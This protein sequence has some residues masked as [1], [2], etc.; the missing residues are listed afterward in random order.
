MASEGKDA[1]APK[2]VFRLDYKRPPFTVTDI[3]LAVALEPEAT[4]VS[5]TL[6]VRRTAAAGDGDD[7]RLDG[8]KLFDA[9]K[10][11]RVNGAELAEGKEGGYTIV[12]EGADVVMVI[13]AAVIGEEATVETQ[14]VFSPRGNTDLQ[15]LYMSD[16]LY[17]TQC[18][19]T[20]FRRIT[21]FTDRPDVLARFTC[22]VEGDKAANP[23]LLSNGNKIESGDLDGG[24]HFA[25]WEDPIPKPSYLFAL[26]AGDL[27][28]I[29]GTFTTKEGKEV[30]LY[31]WSEDK[32]VSRLAHAL[33]SVKRAMKWDE[34]TFGR[35]YDLSRFNAVAVGS[36]NQGAMEN[37]SLN[38]FNTVALVGDH[39]TTTDERLE[40]IMG[41]VGHEFFHHWSGNHVTVRDWFQLTLKEGLTKFRDGWF[42]MDM[43]SAAHK[44]ISDVKRLRETQF[45]EDAGPMAHSIRPD[46]YISFE[47]YYTVTVYW[48]GAEVHRMYLT[49]LGYETFR[50]GTDLYFDRHDGDAVSCD[51][52]RAAMADASGMDLTQFDR[53]YSQAGTPLVEVTSAHDAAAGTFSLTMRQSCPPTPGQPTKLPFHIPVRLGLIDPESGADLPLRLEGEAADAAGAGDTTRVLSLTEAEQTFVFTGVAARP[54]ASLF[55]DFSAPVK[56]VHAQETREDLILMMAHDSD[57]V[58]RWD[59]SQKLGM[60]VVKELLA[61]F[62]AGKTEAELT[63]DDDFVAAFR[64]T[65]TDAALDPSL[66][67][68]ALRLPDVSEIGEA[69]GDVIDFVA[70]ARARRFAVQ[71]LAKRLYDEFK[72]AYDS[73]AVTAPHALDGAQ[74]G[75]RR[76]RGVCLGYITSLGAG[77]AEGGAA[78][79]KAQ[80]DAATNMTEAVSALACLADMDCPQREEALAHFEAKWA[81][82]SLV[83]DTWFSIQA[84]SSL[85]G[86]VDRVRKL[87]E[88]PKYDDKNPNKVRAVLGGFAV[89]NLERFHEA[90]GSGYA[91]LGEVV[92]KMDGINAM[93]A[94]RYAGIFSNYRRLDAARQALVRAELEAIRD[95]EGCSKDTFEIVSKCLKPPADAGGAAGGG[96]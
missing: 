52:F 84:S 63:L 18:E 9:T 67:S 46:S 42:S 54:V 30:G 79:A 80:Y 81:D 39:E 68:L 55:R 64:S 69:M 21:W 74:V 33:E 90:D 34:D 36:F 41:V 2:E 27:A 44:R 31:F 24:R 96:K 16:A 19:A 4:T 95:R 85:P 32:Y 66:K 61:A 65:L 43:T 94:A 76:L 25:V 49:L 58:N 15:G 37:T 73:H 91:F 83:M 29:E 20:G 26:V 92:R 75:A 70:A 89:R 6:T 53:W 51:E 3:K 5:S 7:L 23:V 11:V 38:I 82:N 45:P 57:A 50:K 77:A 8:S 1:E 35:V 71:Q 47:N 14:V 62:A 59:A 22:R 40:Y 48:K 56:V 87:L 78:L 86:A 72:A 88:H 10:Y 93:V 12:Q 13:A 60:A 17:C 28:H